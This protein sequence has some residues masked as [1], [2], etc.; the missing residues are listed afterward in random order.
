MSP[1]IYMI[2]TLWP[3]SR[4][5][6][7]QPAETTRLPPA[8][9]HWEDFCLSSSQAP[10]Q[11]GQVPRFCYP[12][13]MINDTSDPSNDINNQIRC[14][15]Q[16]FSKLYHCV[17]SQHG[18]SVKTKISV[19][20]AIVIPTLLYGSQSRTLYHKNIRTLETFHQPKLRVILGI[21]WEEC[22]SNNDV[23]THA[24]LPSVEAIVAKNQL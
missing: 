1:E 21:C 14:A 16:A 5:V 19:Y 15:H 9:H 24:G 12:G 22:I 7:V 11:L 6:I 23:L 2:Q 20:K 8:L 18:L 3:S 10:P 17:F 4:K 13:S